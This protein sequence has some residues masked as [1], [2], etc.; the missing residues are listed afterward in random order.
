MK[1]TVIGVVLLA[2]GGVGLLTGALPVDEALA[3]GDRVWPILLFVVAITV[4]AE[5][6]ASAGVFDVLAAGLARVSRGRTRVLWVLTVALAILATAFLSLDTT[7]VLLTPVVVSVARAH[8]LDPVPFAFVT[9]VLAN[10]ASLVLPVSNLTNLL[11]ADA[12]GGHDP[13]PFLALVGPSAAIAIV[14]SVAVLA[15][16]FVPRLPRRFPDAAPPRIADRPLLITAAVTV[17]VLLPLLVSG[18]APWI[19]AVVA[20][21]VLIAVHAWRA[22]RALGFTLVPWPLIVFAAGLFLVVGVAEA[23]GSGVVVDAIAGSGD[24]LPA[25]WQVAGVGALAA[26]VVNNLPAYLAL[27]S[28]AQSPERLAALLVGV[29]AG[30]LL[31]P[32]ASLATLLWHDRLRAQGVEVSWRRFVLLGAVIAPLIILTAVVPLAR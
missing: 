15:V 28:V 14:V 23:I 24:D 27:E 22:P 5:L 2:V 26:N 11:A 9:V 12:L 3:I 20:A 16:V 18:L 32:W 6:A 8:R 25:L 17:A 13:L 19:P 10:T 7:A 4:V 21:A 30:P 29:N 1:L 31:T